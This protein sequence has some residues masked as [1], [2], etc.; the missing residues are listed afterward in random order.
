MS[1][2]SA[3]TPPHRPARLRRLALAL[4]TAC[5]LA[6]GSKDPTELTKEEQL[7]LYYENALWYIQLG[8]LDRAQFQAQ[9]GL[10]VDPGNERMSLIMG[11]T[12]VMRGTAESIQAAL[13][14]FEERPD[15]PD[16]R[17]QMTYGA[18]LERKGVLYDEAA[19]AVRDGQ[20]ATKASDRTAR[21]EELLAEAR[22]FWLDARKR[23][24][25]ALE[26]RPGEI[27]ALNG[28]V[29]TNALLGEFGESVRWSEALIEEIHAMQALR[30][31]QLEAPDLTADREAKLREA[32]RID[33]SF[34][35]KTR[36]HT[37]TLLRRIGRQSEA[38]AHIEEVIALEP[39]LPQA[40][41]IRGQLQMEVGE[42]VKARASLQRFLELT[43]LPVEDPQI[44][45]TFDLQDECEKRLRAN[46]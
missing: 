15:L 13:Q 24:E 14:I 5:A 42:Y 31:T 8:D 22:G 12:N 16:Y 40:Y 46:G 37:V 2:P 23:F 6:C 7:G 33:R 9:K 41:S 18:A 17:W 4:A 21:S 39:E 28:L 10:E 1:S 26:K 32:Y 19:R 36:L 11:R 30:R 44:R 43:D 34:E 38:L 3:P 29:R 27:E 45:R 20:R 25:R 35:V